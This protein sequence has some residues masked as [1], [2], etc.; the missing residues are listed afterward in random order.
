M[1]NS[2][3][4]QPHHLD[5][6]AVIYIRQS[7]PHQVLTNTESRMIDDNYFCRSHCLARDVTERGPLPHEAC[8]QRAEGG[9]YV[10][11]DQYQYAARAR[12]GDR[13]SV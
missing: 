1:I 5:R 4:I 13:D 9:R 8:Y 6:K 10:E 12:S 7:T 3:L 11:D 2:E